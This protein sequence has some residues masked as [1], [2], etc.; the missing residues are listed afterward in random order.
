MTYIFGDSFDLYKVEADAV[1]TGYWDSGSGALFA[2]QAAGRFTGS[3]AISFQ[4]AT[5]DALIK[6]SGANDGVHHLV[7]AVKQT[8]VISGTSLGA[9]LV[10]SDGAT[11]QCSLVFRSDGAMLLTSGGPSGTILATYSGAITLQNQWFAFEAEVIVS[12][13]VGGMRVRKNNNTSNDFDS[14]I[15]VGNLNTRTTANN[16]ANRLTVKSGSTSPGQQL[17][18]LLWRSDASS[19]P[20]VGDVRCYTRMPAS[21]ASVVFSRSPTSV[22]NQGISNDSVTGALSANNIRAGRVVSTTTGTVTSLTSTFNAGI[23]GHAKMAVYDNTGSGNGAGALLFSSAELTNPGAGVNTFTVSGSPTVTRGTTYWV[24]LWSDVSITGT[25][26][27]GSSNT[28]GFAQTYTTSFPGSI[29][30]STAGSTAGIGS[31]G[32]NTTSFNVGCV[33][34]AQQDGVTSYVYSSNVGDTDLYNIAS[35]GVTPASTIA[36][37]TRAFVQK[38]DAG[39]RSGKVVLKSGS[40]TV[41]TGSAPLSTTWAQM[42]RTDTVDPATGTAWTAVGVNAAQIGVTVAS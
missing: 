4:S 37:T 5:S 28:C 17:D 27:S 3:Q 9:S 42:W 30:G 34:E 1:G 22:L 31:N 11:A 13:T 38:S 12:N 18:D 7:V 15:S 39:S 6:N 2:L 35:I 21:D 20:F 36:V 24:A 26:S 10:L 14:F 29:T 19:V 16:Y 32:I 33:N 23:T 8:V 40:T 41:D 25:G